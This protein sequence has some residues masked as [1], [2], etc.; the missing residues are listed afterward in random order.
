MPELKS[1]DLFN[2]YYD[3]FGNIFD[4]LNNNNID[5]NFIESW[6]EKYKNKSNVINFLHLAEIKAYN[7]EKTLSQL[8]TRIGIIVSYYLSLNIKN[9]TKFEIWRIYLKFSQI[10]ILIAICFIINFLDFVF[11]LWEKKWNKMKLIK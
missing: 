9:K 8:K 7:E 5:Q 1:N 2:F 10:W 3:D 6:V 4:Y 11:Y